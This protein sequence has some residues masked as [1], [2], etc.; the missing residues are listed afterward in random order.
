[1]TRPAESVDEPDA[2]EAEH[3]GERVEVAVLVEHAEAAFG[4]GR[5]DQV[6]RSGEATAAAQFTGGAERCAAG[7]GGHGACGSASS[8]WA[9]RCTR[10][11]RGRRRAARARLPGRRPSTRLE[12]WLPSAAD[13][14]VAWRTQA[15]VSTTSGTVANGSAK[16]G[17]ALGVDLA[18]S[19]EV[20]VG[21]AARDAQQVV[22]GGGRRALRSPRARRR[23]WRGL[24]SAVTG[25]VDRGRWR[26]SPRPAPGRRSPVRG[27]RGRHAIECTEGWYTAA[28]SGAYGPQ[29]RFEG[30]RHPLVPAREG[31]TTPVTVL[32]RRRLPRADQPPPRPAEPAGPA[33]LDARRSLVLRRRAEVRVDGVVSSRP[34]GT[35]TVWLGRRGAGRARARLPRAYD[36]P[37]PVP[38][39]TRSARR[40]G[41]WTST[42][43]DRV[44]RG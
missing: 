1:M 27:L 10:L 20:V 22:G 29:L 39:R 38:T 5:G 25:W 12:V 17:F 32:L 8:A 7:A 21:V 34:S 3:R 31:R 19:L 2:L 6:V 43:C 28:S 11:R 14:G 33:P 42:R 35:A 9:R 26:P 15:E 37:R 40:A 4:G 30:A 16:V 18:R 41:P 36:R 44:S 24:G 13:R 23:G